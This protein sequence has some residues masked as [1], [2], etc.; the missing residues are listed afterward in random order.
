[1]L[2]QE[3][4]TAAERPV[5]LTPEQIFASP[6]SMSF[7]KFGSILFGTVIREIHIRDPETSAER[8]SEINIEI[9]QRCQEIGIKRDHLDLLERQMHALIKDREAL[10]V[11]M[12]PLDGIS[13][14]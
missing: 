8:I 2:R 4:L 13:K 3:V 9:D 1:M 5:V 7:S 6:D 10:V 14:I 11:K 12:F